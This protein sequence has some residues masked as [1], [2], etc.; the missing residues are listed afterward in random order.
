MCA[1]LGS[2][3]ETDGPATLPFHGVQKK[4]LAGAA[5]GQQSE[6]QSSRAARNG[7]SNRGG[8]EAGGRQSTAGTGNVLT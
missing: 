3:V 2:S 5:Q 1:A 6:Q 8:G 4:Q 7:G